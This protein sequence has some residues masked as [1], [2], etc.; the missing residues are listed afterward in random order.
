[1]ISLGDLAARRPRRG[2]GP[3]TTHT[4]A[5]KAPAM[6]T[7]EQIGQPSN[8]KQST[9]PRD[10]DRTRFNGLKH[11]LRAE[12]VVLPGEDPAD[13]EAERRAWLDDW[14]PL[15]H[16]RAVLVERAAVASWRLRRAVRSEAALRAGSPTTPAAPSTPRPPRRVERAID[17]F[18]DDPAAALSLLES[19]AAGLDRLLALLGRAGRGPGAGPAGWDQPLYHDAADAPAGPPA[20]ADADEAGPA[21]ASP[22]RGCCG[23]RPGPGGRTCRC[24]GRGRGG[25]RG[26]APD[27]RAEEMAR[28]RELRRGPPT[29]PEAAPGD[30]GGRGRHSTEA[31]LRHRYE[32][33]HERSL[34]STIRAAPGAGEVRRR[35]ARAARGRARGH[36]GGRGRGRRRPGRAGFPGKSDANNEPSKIAENWLRSA[37]RP[38]PGPGRASSGSPGPRPADRGRSGAESAPNRP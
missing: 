9:G 16:T 29:R 28:L 20:D 15:S 38:R 32:M 12:Q 8:A 4:R 10:T 18:D 1:M 23:P 33:A 27:G 5:R 35:P 6:A 26:A 7:R 13:F 25:L 24:G 37:R 2:A 31:Q 30:G 3:A 21:A 14:K 17:R 36:P 34:R 22:R 11:G 19:H